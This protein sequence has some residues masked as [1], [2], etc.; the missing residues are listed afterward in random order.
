MKFVI[1]LAGIALTIVFDVAV[2]EDITRRVA[3]DGQLVMEDV[4]EIP[5]NIV[6]DLNRYQNVRSAG[7]RAWTEDGS[8]YAV[9]SFMVLDE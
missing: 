3:N 2:A 1:G 8:G 6:D 5:A 9:T 4:P 7:F